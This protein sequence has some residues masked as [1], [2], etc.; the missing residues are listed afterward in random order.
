VK[1]L[2]DLPCSEASGSSNIRT[3]PQGKGNREPEE[4]VR[5]DSV[6]IITGS[7]PTALYCRAH[8]CT[9]SPGNRY[10][11]C[12]LCRDWRNYIWSMRSPGDM[13]HWFGKAFLCV[14]GTD[15]VGCNVWTFARWHI[16]SDV[17]PTRPWIVPK[18]YSAA[19]A[20]GH[21]LL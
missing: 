10:L 3:T 16:S 9:Q 8:C 21:L 18:S 2:D 6:L 1:I 4:T 17:K 7:I 11:P 19:G 14:G 12:Y 13:N 5:Q 15:K 20:N